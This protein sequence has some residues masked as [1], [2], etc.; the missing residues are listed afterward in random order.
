MPRPDQR[1]R[2]LLRR[3]TA[4]LSIHLL[5]LARDVLCGNRSSRSIEVL[6]LSIAR[7]TVSQHNIAGQYLALRRN[8]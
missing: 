1:P 4:I 3:N 8:R 2:Q 5:I 6:K 7:S